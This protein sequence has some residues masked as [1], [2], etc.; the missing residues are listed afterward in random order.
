MYN[1]LHLAQNPGKIL[2]PLQFLPLEVALMVCQYLNT[3]DRVYDFPPNV[4]HS[5]TNF[6]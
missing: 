2:D 1:K 5:F 6:L 3:R 4:N